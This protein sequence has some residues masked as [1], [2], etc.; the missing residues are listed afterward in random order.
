[1]SFLIDG[2]RTSGEDIRSQNVTACVAIANIVK[3]SLGPVGLDKMLV[4]QI[5]EVTITNDGATILKQLEVE[6]PAAKVLCELADLQ[7]QEVGDG[8]TSV[9]I[10]AAEL[11]KRGN[12]L[13]RQRIHPTSII[14]GF[15]LAM[16]EA[17]R[18]VKENLVIKSDTLAREHLIN[19]AKTSMS[20]K[21]IG[22][23]S[24]FFAS[25]VVDA[26]TAV[27]TESGGRAKFPVGAINIL[28]AHGRSSRESELVNGFALNCTRAAQGMPTSVK[29]ARI[30]LLDFDLRRHRMQMGVQ[31]L[32]TNPRELEAVQ[33]REMDITRDKIRKI[34]DA[35]A[36]VILTT[37][38][39]DDLCLKYLVES[40][41]IGVRRVKKE[42]L[43]RIARAT[44]GQVL[45][46]MATLEGEEEVDPETL[47]RAE[48]VS[49]DRVGD[50]ELIYI[51]G[52]AT[53]RA[54]TIVLRGPNEYMLDEMDRSLHDALMVIKRCLENR[55]LVVGGGAVEGAL[56]V[57]LDQFA[58]TLGSREQL[59]VHEFAQALLVIPKTLATNAACDVTE[60]VAR[61]CAKHAKSQREGGDEEL[62]HSGLD[63]VK[64]VVLNNLERGVV[65]P[66]ISKIKSLRFAT[67]AA[68][69]ILRIDDSIKVNPKEEDHSGHPHP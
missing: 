13:V 10:L 44:G 24:D 9:V 7:D 29:D 53:S 42:D 19:A 4:D 25:M 57:Y 37:K 2:T 46:T 52:C 64:G 54:T 11:L 31:V 20:S 63:L 40:G 51:R 21:I 3:S 59:A 33:Q 43:R 65:E 48:L 58:T 55:A 35:G 8:T 32:I 38:G 50:H 16:K 18:Y 67:E 47:G 22:A 6:H 27:R 34:L 56:H 62:R 14:S 60:L 45:V 17:V 41:V 69:T 49:E 23:E 1:M 12:E 68:V 36:N 5:G 66:A 30:A 39:I 15:R 28:K 26:V 61:L